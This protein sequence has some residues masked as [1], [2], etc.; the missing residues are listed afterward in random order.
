MKNY[1]CIY[2]K[3][4]STYSELENLELLHIL[5]LRMLKQC[6]KLFLKCNANAFVYILV[7]KCKK[8]NE[9]NRRVP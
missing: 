4:M 5:L 1:E 8:Y 6:E 7:K 3:N 9:K 2:L